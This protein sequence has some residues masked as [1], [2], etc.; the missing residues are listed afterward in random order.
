MPRKNHI[1]N[2]SANKIGSTPW[3]RN[4]FQ[5]GSGSMFHSDAQS[6][7]GEKSAITE[8]TTMIAIEM[9]D[10]TIANRNEMCAPAEFSAMKTAY[11]MMYSTQ[12]GR[13]MPRSGSRM[14]LT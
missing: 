7:A 1:A 14:P 4:S 10:T 8:N 13:V 12:P 6:S 11:R 9:I 2:G 3:G 5:P